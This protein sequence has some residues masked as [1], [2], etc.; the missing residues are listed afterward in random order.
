MYALCCGTSL[1]ALVVK[2]TPANAADVRD[3]PL[4]PGSGWPTGEGN[5]SPSIPAWRIPWTEEPGALYDIPWGRKVS[6]TTE[7]T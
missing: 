7:A 3:V 1:A 2:N 4:T 5:G 6:D